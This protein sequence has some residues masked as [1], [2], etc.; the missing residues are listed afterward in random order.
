MHLL[1]SYNKDFISFMNTLIIIQIKA[2]VKTVYNSCYHGRVSESEFV[3]C[4]FL[5]LR[6]CTIM[7]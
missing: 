6:G 2:M 4:R 3:G 7:L 1:F 5:L